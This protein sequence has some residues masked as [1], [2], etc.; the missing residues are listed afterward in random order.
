MDFDDEQPQTKSITFVCGFFDAFQVLSAI[1]VYSF[2]VGF[3]N[4]IKLLNRILVIYVFLPCGAL[5]SGCLVLGHDDLS[6][7]MF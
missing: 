7:L 2:L 5:R 3:T 6:K 4:L 1:L